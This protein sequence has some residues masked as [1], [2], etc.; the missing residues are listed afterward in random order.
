MADII[1]RVQYFYTETADKP[2]EGARLLG[3][4]RDE[5]VDLLCFSGFPKGRR[6]QIDFVPVDPVALKAAAKKAR[7]KLVGPKTTFLI[8]GED[9]VGAVADFMSKLAEARINVTALQAIAAG[10]GQYG[11]ILWVKSRDV[12]KAAKVL[13][14]I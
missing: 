4:L 9:R 1:K 13:Q 10:A 8:Q 14:P 5:G 11:A 3:L 6:A 12:N 7:F 2:G